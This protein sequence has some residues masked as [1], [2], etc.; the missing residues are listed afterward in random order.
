MPSGITL[1]SGIVTGAPA[2]LDA[3]FGPYNSVTDALND[4]TSG[5]RYRGLTVGVFVSGVLKEYWFRDGTEN[6]DFVQKISD[7]TWDSLPGKPSTFA[8]S[9]HTHAISD[10]TN[11]QTTLDGKQASGFYATLES[12][13]VPISQIPSHTHIITD[14]VNLTQALSGKAPSAHT[15]AIS[16]VTSLQT[17]LDG[18]AAQVHDHDERYYTEDETDALLALNVADN[19]PRIANILK[20]GTADGA[21]IGG[22]GGSINLS[23]GDAVAEIA[24]DGGAGGSI[25]LRGGS[26]VPVIPGDVASPALS[27]AGNGGSIIL[28]GADVAADSLAGNSGSINLSAL[29]QQ[30]G[31]SIDLRSLSTSN[32]GGN[33]SAVAYS[34]GAGSLNM[35]GSSDLSFDDDLSGGSIT[36]KDGGGSIDTTGTGSIGL[37]TIGTRT[38]LTGT[39]TANRAISLPD[40]GGTIALTSDLLCAVFLPTD[41]Q[42]PA[43]AFATL[44]TRNQI[45]VCDFDDTMTESAVFVGI[46]PS[47]VN[48][49]GGIIVRLPFVAGA[50]SGSVR[51]SV[52]FERCNTDLDTDSFGSA[53]V[54][55]VATSTTSGIPVVASITCAS[56]DGISAGD[57]F[58]VRVQRL[59]A[60]ATDTMTGDAELIAV[61]LRSAA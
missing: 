34:H 19:D 27:S 42:P 39:A 2:A 41:N 61:E 48:L 20:S 32:N 13:K 55:T 58:R 15:H 17:S 8:P 22:L 16:D 52:A 23:G 4:L 29:S 44:D 21:K 10:V 18:K 45:E 31:G 6:T 14:V 46:M 5:L 3:K 1:I 24:A 54:A 49:T 12:G 33:I 30:N 25:D 50:T 35:S 53:N 47:G 7:V 26:G 56:I 36:T 60:H 57:L 28:R 59:G 9:A 40:K 11:L 38:T 43:S 51:W 37:G